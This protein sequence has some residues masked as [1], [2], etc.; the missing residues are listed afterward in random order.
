[1]L[2]FPGLGISKLLGNHQFCFY[3]FLLPHN[4][5]NNSVPKM[6]T[7]KW[8]YIYNIYWIISE[9][10][11][12]PS[13]AGRRTVWPWWQTPT[14][15]RWLSIQVSRRLTGTWNCSPGSPPS[16]RTDAPYNVVLMWYSM[17]MPLNVYTVLF[18]PVIILWSKKIKDM[19]QYKWLF[20][21]ITVFLLYLRSLKNNNFFC[22]SKNWNHSKADRKF[23]TKYK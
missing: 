1:V 12:S 3:W 9:W 23:R 11:T 18:T 2:R 8:L 14:A 5:F 15:P 4:P 6:L 21:S 20:L 17:V 10:Y 7:L 16:S 13:S 22:W 19:K